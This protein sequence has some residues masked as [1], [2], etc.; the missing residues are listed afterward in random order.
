MSINKANIAPNASIAPPSILVVEDEGLISLDIETHLLNLGYQISG[1]AETG[2]ASIEKALEARPDLIL[3]DIRLKGEMDGIEA[4]SAITA[5]LDVP[6]IFL[7]AFADPETLKRAKQISPFGYILKPFDTIDLRTSIE[8]A[9]QKHRSDK[10][11]KRQKNWLNTVLESIGDAVITTD[12]VGNITFINR[13]A[14]SLTQWSKAEALG[15]NINDVMPLMSSEKSPIENPILQALQRGQGDAFT[16]GTLLV[17]KNQQE[18]PVEDSAVLILDANQEVHGAVIVFR[19]VTERLKAKQQLFHHAYY[20]ALTNLPNRSFFMERVQHVIDLNQRYNNC[21]YAV[22]FVDLDRFKIVNDSLGHPLG[23]Q[24]LIT[25]AQRLQDCLRSTDIVA[26]FGGDEFV[27]LVEQIS[28]LDIVCRLAQRINRELST[29]CRLG[30]GEFFSSASIGIVQGK[31]QYA[32]AEDLIRDADIA[33]YQAKANGKGCYAIFDEAIHG[34]VKGRL[35]LENDLR[36]AIT[37][38]TLTVYYQP[39]VS[40]VTQQITG[41]EALVRW[42]HP[43]RGFIPPDVFIPI[44]EETGLIVQLD[45]WVLCQAC[46][47]VKAW[48]EQSPQSAQLSVSVNLSSH[49]FSQSGVVHQVKQ[50]LAETKLPVESLRLEITETALIENPRS[51]AQI[52]S[53]LKQLG[54]QISIDDFGTGYSS[55]SYL[56]KYP[57]D[58]LKVDRS[59]I[60][61]IDRN[62]N[63]FE[64]ARTIIILAKALNMAA[65]AEGIETAEQLAAMKSLDCDYAQGYYFYRPL[66]GEQVTA[67]LMNAQDSPS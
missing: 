34:P 26:R 52:L 15:K 40:L 16:E 44:A 67:L 36:R 27:I 63:Q 38:H 65:I 1:I 50:T 42:R 66:S 58:T 18:V 2:Q 9:L 51:A 59:F 39:I 56:H 41:V 23:D 35:T 6:I 55:L 19:D 11:I 46:H 4:A 48:Q 28:D 32:K 8:I 25:T 12:I 57:I 33:M 61:N 60:Q 30:N 7:T 13:V 21:K 29:P 14:E 3:M 47:Q 43:E 24:L 62:S 20:D 5:Q 17:T 45:R 54:T 37:D 53:E 22:L 64:I 31:S 49:H 10:V